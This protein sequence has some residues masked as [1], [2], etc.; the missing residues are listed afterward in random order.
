MSYKMRDRIA[1]IINDKKHVHE[2]IAIARMILEAML[3]PTDEMVQAAIGSTSAFHDIKGSQL[4]VNREKVR[5]RWRAMINSA[6]RDR[7]PEA[8]NT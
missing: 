3:E 4:T 2:P 5:I 7:R 6:L 1:E 8:L